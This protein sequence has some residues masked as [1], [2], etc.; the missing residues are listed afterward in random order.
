VLPRVCFACV[1]YGE[2]EKVYLER[3]FAAFTRVSPHILAWQDHREKTA[4]HEPLTLVGDAWDGAA[5]MRLRRRLARW[6]GGDEHA[7]SSSE[8]RRLTERIRDLAPDVVYAHLGF[9]GLRLLPV[10]RA[11]GVP[12]VTHF[13]GVDIHQ[14]WRNPR[15]AKRLLSAME[16]FDR[17]ILVARYMERWVRE[18]GGRTDH[19]VVIPMGAPIRAEEPPPPADSSELRVLSVGRLIAYKGFDRAIDA[20]AAVRPRFPNVRLRIVGEGPLR[21]ALEAQIQRLGLTRHVELLGEQPPARTLQLFEW[22]DLV[23]HPASD[24]PDGPEAASVV[25]TE[26]MSNGRPVLGTVCGGIPDQVIPGETGI[27]VPQHDARA[28]H[29]ALE[30]LLAD[31]SSRRRL[32]KAGRA[33][34]V[35]RFD[36]QHQAR[37][38]ED[39][40]LDV[41]GAQSRR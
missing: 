23:L 38:V 3:Q 13:H 30:A 4:A 19:V 31:E 12:L 7:A 22:C 11:L 37:N 26:A 28:L 14:A 40:L 15:L 8:R 17:V 20:I 24:D 10:T 39:V 1:R 18:Q 25:I 27:L 2:P 6:S 35:E 32:G 16:L 29:Q 21:G 34:A 5:P 33:L 41:I 9:V 36:A